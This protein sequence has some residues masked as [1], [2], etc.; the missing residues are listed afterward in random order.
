MSVGAWDP[1]SQVAALDASVLKALLQAAERLEQQDFGLSPAEAER[2]AGA[3]QLGAKAWQAAAGL[4]NAELIALVRLFTLAESRLPGWKAG[5]NNPV[6][7]L[8]A[9]L[10]RR[11]AWPAELTAWVKAHSDNRFLPYGSLADRLQKSAP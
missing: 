7:P 10:R 2:L 5:A 3:A 8:C 4:T 1:S 9:M 11:G 6:I